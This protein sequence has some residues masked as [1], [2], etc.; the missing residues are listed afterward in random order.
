MMRAASLG[1]LK[2]IE[3][4]RAEASK[5]LER[6]PNI[7]Y[8]VRE[9]WLRKYNVPEEVIERIVDGLRKGGLDI[10]DEER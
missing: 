5:L 4:A 8:T 10:P 1:Q 2:R 3:E 7:P 9:H 6:H